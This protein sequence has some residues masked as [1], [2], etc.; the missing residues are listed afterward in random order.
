MSGKLYFKYGCMN[1]GKSL[2][3][4]SQAHSLDEQGVSVLCMKPS[5]DTRDGDGVIK[6]RV[7]IAKECVMIEDDLNVFSYLEDLF[8]NYTLHAIDTP[9]WIIIDECQFLQP[10]QVEQIAEFVDK[11][12]VNVMCYGIRTDFTGHLF[13]GSKRLM[14]LSD[15][16]EEIKMSCGCGRKATMNARFD[17]NGNII[18]EGDVVAIGG[19]SMYRALCRKCYNSLVFAAK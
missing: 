16:I 7:G 9:R 3:L 12:G 10:E 1:S 11:Y 15:C 6:S 17:V 4:L 5:A 18:T 14:E 2:M 8:V 13:P 19:N